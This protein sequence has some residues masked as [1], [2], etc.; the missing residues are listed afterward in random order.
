VNSKSIKIIL[1][2]SECK[3]AMS[4]GF[5]EAPYVINDIIPDVNG[6]HILDV[7]IGYGFWG[8]VVKAWKAGKCQLTGVE[9]NDHYISRQDKLNIYDEIVPMDIRTGL[10][11]FEDNSFDLIMMSHV[12]EHIE[13]NTAF[14]VIE[15]LK[16][17]C[18]GRLIILCPEGNAIVYKGR[19]GNKF[20]HDYHLSMWRASDFEKLGFN[21][22]Q[23]RFSHSAGRMVSWFERI[24]FW[25]KRL[26]RGGVLAAWCD[27][28]IN[29]ILSPE[30]ENSKNPIITELPRATTE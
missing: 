6:L 9:I 7:G 13:K 3:S 10:T 20:E 28:D 11:I 16:R 15:Q 23:L 21:I 17:I 27:L 14:K 1:I 29:K 5:V 4:S 24:W 30:A 2:S 12:I 18:R 26:D 22:K 8:W 19:K 25:L